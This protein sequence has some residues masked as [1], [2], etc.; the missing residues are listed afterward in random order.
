MYY[1]ILGFE[2]E[3]AT[4]LREGVEKVSGNRLERSQNISSPSG[5]KQRQAGRALDWVNRH[6]AR[7]IISE[8]M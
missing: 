5:L 4:V 2:G 3:G 6:L 7:W 8:W 1:G